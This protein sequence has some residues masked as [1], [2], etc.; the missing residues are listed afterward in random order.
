MSASS[1]TGKGPGS[2]PVS[3][4]NGKAKGWNYSS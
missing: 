1:V 3:A 4:S 2:V